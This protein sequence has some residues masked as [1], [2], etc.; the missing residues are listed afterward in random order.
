MELSCDIV[1]ESKSKVS[2]DLLI[3]AVL[4]TLTPQNTCWRYRLLKLSIIS[5]A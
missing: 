3:K 5:I 4:R 1:V 2:E